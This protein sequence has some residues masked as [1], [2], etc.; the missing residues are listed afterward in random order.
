MR[1][2]AMS[3][4]EKTECGRNSKCAKKEDGDDDDDEN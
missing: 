2:A 1:D 4:H 3:Q